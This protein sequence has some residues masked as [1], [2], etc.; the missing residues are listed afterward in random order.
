[1]PRRLVRNPEIRAT[2]R[3][4]S[5]NRAG[6]IIDA[7]QHVRVKS[8]S[9]EIGSTRA[10]QN[11]KHRG[12]GCFHAD[13]FLTALPPTFAFSRTERTKQ[14]REVDIAGRSPVG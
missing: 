6:V 1:M 2:D 14:A 12:Y 13:T 8:G 10:A 7:K 4:A 11:G 5:D 9:V 3:A